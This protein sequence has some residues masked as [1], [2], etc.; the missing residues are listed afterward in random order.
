MMQGKEFNLFYFILILSYLI[1]SLCA[2]SDLGG[3]AALLSFSLIVKVD[4]K[5]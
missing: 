5:I 2:L 4:L 3:V 1:Y